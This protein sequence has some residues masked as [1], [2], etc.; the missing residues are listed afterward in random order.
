MLCLIQKLWKLRDRPR[1]ILWSAAALERAE[2]V[3]PA[4]V[5]EVFF[6]NVLSAK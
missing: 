1:L 6:G 4:D 5:Q 3:N 2:G